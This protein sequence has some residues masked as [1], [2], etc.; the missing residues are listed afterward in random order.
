MCQTTAAWASGTVMDV[1]VQLDSQAMW[2]R[3]CTGLEHAT[4][5]QVRAAGAAG[6]EGAGLARTRARLQ[7]RAAQE[8]ELM[9]RV[10]LSR[11]ERK[12]LGRQRR[13]GMAGGA[14]L[15]DFADDIA[16]LVEVRCEACSGVSYST[17]ACADTM[18]AWPRP[19]SGALLRLQCR[20]GPLSW[21]FD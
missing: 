8:E 18:A 3:V 2:Q 16:G 14:M 1:E 12:D 6:E 17:G 9:A 20:F 15:D 5:V 13:A 19:Q 10:P 11:A 4:C 7:A 21:C